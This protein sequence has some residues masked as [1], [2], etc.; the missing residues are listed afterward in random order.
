MGGGGGHRNVEGSGGT[1]G[2]T[3]IWRG[4]RELGTLI[5]RYHSMFINILK[6]IRLLKLWSRPGL[7]RYG[8]ETQTAAQD[9]QREITHK[10]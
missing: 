1:E 6:G 4:Q 9:Y 5:I 8:A 2:G 10:V 3:G 7:Y